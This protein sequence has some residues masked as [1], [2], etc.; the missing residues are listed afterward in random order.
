M[1]QAGVVAAA[2]ATATPT[3][4]AAPAAPAHPQQ[5]SARQVMKMHRFE[6][7]VTSLGRQVKDGTQE[8]GFN[9]KFEGSPKPVFVDKTTAK[10]LFPKVSEIKLLKYIYFYYMLLIYT[11]HLII[12][13]SAGKAL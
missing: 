1:H 6:R 5:Q 4:S 13:S 3:S 2:A 8:F 10:L 12:F 9:F 7:R 11:F